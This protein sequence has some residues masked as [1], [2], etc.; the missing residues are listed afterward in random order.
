MRLA[1]GVVAGLV[2]ASTAAAQA[3]STPDL[4]RRIA[5]YDELL[6]GPARDPSQPVSAA[7]QA[8]LDN[9]TELLTALEKRFYEVPAIETLAWYGSVAEDVAYLGVN[10]RTDPKT[11]SVAPS[12]PGA[13]TW[14]RTARGN[15]KRMTGH[16]ER[17]WSA[18]SP[19]PRFGGYTYEAT[20][21]ANPASWHEQLESVVVRWFNPVKASLLKQDTDT[22][23]VSGEPLTKR[24]MIRGRAG[25]VQYAA[26][27]S[28]LTV[29]ASVDSP[30]SSAGG[31]R[32]ANS[33]VEFLKGQPAP[34]PMKFVNAGSYGIDGLLGTIGVEV[35][36][37][38]SLA[39][40]A[41]T[42]E[43]AV[44]ASGVRVTGSHQHCGPTQGVRVGFDAPLKSEPLAY[45]ATL[46]DFDPRKTVVRALGTIQEES[47]PAGSGMPPFRYAGFR[48]DLDGDGQSDLLVVQGR[49]KAELGTSGLY[50]EEDSL[51]SA[52]WANIGGTWKRVALASESGCT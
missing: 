49:G 26:E 48:I 35:A 50:A 47:S 36:A 4:A 41:V 2:L 16:M 42:R 19:W 8:L 5:A 45:V 43:G 24:Q 34:F 23:V 52:V 39:V 12:V 51:L 1:I 21:P 29:F 20:A 14:I 15:W 44:R 17:G 46:R 11:G 30:R 31:F 25:A 10:R 33:F 22:Y 38:T 3:T 7:G 37:P 18:G 13:N 40:F 28:A 32:S 9:P 27:I 6:N